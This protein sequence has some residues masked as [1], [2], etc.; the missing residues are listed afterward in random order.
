MERSA[1]LERE[2]RSLETVLATLER[3]VALLS[4]TSPNPDYVDELARGILGF[5]RHGEHI[6]VARPPRS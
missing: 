3:D 2:I 6:L 4:E 5:A 1:T